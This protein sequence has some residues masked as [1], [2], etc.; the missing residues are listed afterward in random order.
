MSY[1][2]WIMIS[3][4]VGAGIGYLFIRPAVLHW[5]ERKQDSVNGE[6]GICQGSELQVK[7]LNGVNEKDGSSKQDETNNKNNE[8]CI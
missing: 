7:F 8:T 4:I 5:L 3:V 2:V 6:A 1:N